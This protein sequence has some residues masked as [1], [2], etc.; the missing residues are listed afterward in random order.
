MVPISLGP[1]GLV[2]IRISAW[3][4]GWGRWEPSQRLTTETTGSAGIRGQAEAARLEEFGGQKGQQPYRTGER[5]SFR[6]LGG[7][8]LCLHSGG[9]PTVSEESASFTA[10]S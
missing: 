6:E 1:A 10:S 5:M 7:L 4:R 9:E 2:S 3:G 8:I